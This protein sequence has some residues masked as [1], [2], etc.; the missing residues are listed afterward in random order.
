MKAGKYAT[1]PVNW[2]KPG[3]DGEDKAKYGWDF[4]SVPMTP[5]LRP[6]ISTGSV[7]PTMNGIAYT[8]K[9]PERT[10]MLLELFNTNVD[11]YNLICKGIEG[12]HWVWVDQAKKLIGFPEGVDAS[13]SRYNP[14]TDWMFGNQ[15]N[16]YY[17]DIT[18]AEADVWAETRAL[19]E[20]ALVSPAMGFAFD[21][22]P[23]E[24][25]IAQTSSASEYGQPLSQGLIDTDPTLE[26]HIKLL[27]DA[28]ADDI[29]AEAKKQLSE[30]LASRG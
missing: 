6:W 3:R 4:V 21:Q 11:L 8:C 16:A 24:T 15:F 25:Q 18:Q 23:V 12:Q 7:I 27:R 17:V 2:A 10:A 5:I 29:V 26:E 1:V 28:G 20:G 22:T 14:N 9:D 30:F 13:N 19:N